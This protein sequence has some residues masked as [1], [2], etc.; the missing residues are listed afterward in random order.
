LFSPHRYNVQQ[1][2]LTKHALM[3]QLMAIPAQ[4]YQITHFVR[5][6]RTPVD[7]VVNVNGSAR[8]NFATRNI[9]LPDVEMF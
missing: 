9:L 6:T 4:T 3:R 1:K 5:A 7:N 2:L 8:A